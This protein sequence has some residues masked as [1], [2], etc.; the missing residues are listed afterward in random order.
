[1]ELGSAT[2]GWML[3]GERK[4]KTSGRH[5]HTAGRAGR[6]EAG[7]HGDGPSVFCFLFCSKIDD[8]FDEGRKM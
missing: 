3:T 6:I 2:D 4:M 8:A 5:R 1:M 7:R